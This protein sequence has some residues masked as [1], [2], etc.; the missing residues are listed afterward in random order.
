[1]FVFEEHVP[2]EYQNALLTPPKKRHIFNRFPRH[3]VSKAQEHRQIEIAAR[4]KKHQSKRVAVDWSSIAARSTIFGV[5]A[6]P[7][8]VSQFV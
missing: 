2:Q 1:M 4:L 5:E 8:V 6:S 3:S 7:A